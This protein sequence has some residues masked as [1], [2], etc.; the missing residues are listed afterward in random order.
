MREITV[1]DGAL[2]WDIVDLA[3]PWLTT[4]STVIQHHGIGTNAGM[5][6][7]WLPR[8]AACHRVVRTARQGCAPCPP[9]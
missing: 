6:S 4:P 1:A 9:A 8:L 3:P 7:E 5:W 2:A